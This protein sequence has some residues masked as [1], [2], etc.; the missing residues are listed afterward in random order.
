MN[1][2]V[3]YMLMLTGEI[4]KRISSTNSDL[5]MK[6]I[7]DYVNK[8][9]DKDLKVETLAERFNYNNAYLGQLFKSSTG[10]YFNAYVDRLRIENAKKFLIMGLKT[11]EVAQK[12]GFKNLDYFYNKF[13]KL[14]GVGPSEYRKNNGQEVVK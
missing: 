2:L 3:E 10:E 11:T 5:I 14:V 7:I 6:R 8:N 1:E 9:Y 12:T 13:K 4:S